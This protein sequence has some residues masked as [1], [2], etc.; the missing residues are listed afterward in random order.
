MIAPD[1]P[2][3]R[4]P[5][6]GRRRRRAVLIALIL[7]LLYGWTLQDLDLGT[8]GLAQGLLMAKNMLLGMMHPEWSYAGEAFLRL[9]ES[10]EMAFLGTAAA[11]ILAV[12]FA[13]WAASRGRRFHVV[14][15][16]GKG[17]L[18]AIR[19][20]PELILAIL[21]L[22]AVGPGPFAGVLA[23]AVHSIGMLGKLYAEA[24]ENIDPGPVE[25]LEAAGA[26]RLA[27][28]FYAV[29]PQVLP[30]FASVALYRFEINVR[31]ATVLGVVG[32]GGIGTPLLFALQAYAWDRVGIILLLVIASVMLIDAASGRL[33]ARLV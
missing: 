22:V 8:R 33:R 12:P 10:I 3:P 26:G 2:L 24:V 14:P 11:A 27:V 31:A 20:F 7:I 32:A 9:L 5:A 6:A 30:E 18:S 25:A 21:F 4:D 15:A 13:F 19:T 28:F 17:A 1:R 29:L 23:I 16:T